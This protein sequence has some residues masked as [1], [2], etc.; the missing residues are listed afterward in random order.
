MSD[1]VN[2]CPY[3]GERVDASIRYCPKCG[4]RIPR[5]EPPPSQTAYQPPPSP[6]PAYQQPP[7]QAPYY[8]APYAETRHRR[9]EK[10]TAAIVL[11]LIGGLFILINGLLVAAV[12]TFALAFFGS[13]ILWI[14][15]G[16][17]FGFGTLL[18]A[19]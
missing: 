4:T 16:L 10:H 3:C 11:S 2:Y 19:L 17:V 5:A 1:G 12:G 7:Q 9:D 15:L 8:Q 18:G 6:P 13:G 14:I